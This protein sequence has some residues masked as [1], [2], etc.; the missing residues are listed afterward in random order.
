MILS[1]FGI[2]EK[3]KVVIEAV[4]ESRDL[5]TIYRGGVA[6]ATEKLS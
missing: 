2:G 6:A 1:K 3:E 5:V 4:Q